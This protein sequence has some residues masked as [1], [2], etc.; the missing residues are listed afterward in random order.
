[1]WGVPSAESFQDQ[2]G[3][4]IANDE[5]LIQ[6]PSHHRDEPVNENVIENDNNIEI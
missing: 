2:L 3:N 1:M 5:N 4:D 6:Q